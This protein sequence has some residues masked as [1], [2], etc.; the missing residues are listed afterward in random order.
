MIRLHA[1]G[2][3]FGLPDPS[4]FVV[5]TEVLLKMAGVAYEK[6]RADPRKGPKGKIP[7]IEDDGRIVPDSTFIRLHLEATRGFDFDKGLTDEQKGAAWALEKLLEDHVYWLIVIERWLDPDNFAKGPRKFF[8][9][10]PALV[11]PLVLA[12]VN[13]QV[14]KVLHG[15]G[16]GRHSA[17]ERAVLAERAAA[18]VAG[19]LGDNAWIGGNE[20][21]GADA[22][23]YA[24][25]A[26]ATCQR[27]TGPVRAAFERHPNLI[28]Y[29]V[30]GTARWFPEVSAKPAAAG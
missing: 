26:S 8:D 20:P 24:F 7:W 30:R 3:A 6:R 25:V 18:A 12:M 13:R 21:C 22:T 10:V 23:A 15:H 1:Y 27:F 16:I 19:C 28:E 5:K 4:P 14:G 2:P 17:A 9:D 11:R 29:S